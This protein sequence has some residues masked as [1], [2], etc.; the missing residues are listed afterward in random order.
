MDCRAGLS[1]WIGS[2]GLAIVYTE[3][4][5]RDITTWVC[6]LSTLLIAAISSQSG[7]PHAHLSA[8]FDI[9]VIEDSDVASEPDVPS[10]PDGTR[11]G[12]TMTKCD[13]S[14]CM[15]HFL[16]AYFSAILSPSS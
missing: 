6:Y 2:E 4:W 12:T 3:M 7:S 13:A 8:P 16:A 10:D 9:L 11:G 15:M 14:S 1:Q 5:L